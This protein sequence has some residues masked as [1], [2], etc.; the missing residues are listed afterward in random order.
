MFEDMFLVK[1][2]SKGTTL[3]DIN[4]LNHGTRESLE[5][6]LPMHKAKCTLY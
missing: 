1:I 6:Y 2:V 4:E 5:F 3:K